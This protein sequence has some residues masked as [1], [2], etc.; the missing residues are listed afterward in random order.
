MPRWMWPLLPVGVAGYILSFLHAPEG[1]LFALTTIGIVPLAALIGKS[2][3]E[4]AYR[5]GSAAGGLL[6]VTFGNVPELI[7]GILAV[8][9]GLVSLAQATIVG[10]VIGNASLVVGMSL[11]YGG[12]RNGVQHFSREE[13]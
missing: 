5:V 11:F 3:E 12:I 8:R 13:V 4:L 1:V 6:N 9:Q 7:I 2:T 10:S